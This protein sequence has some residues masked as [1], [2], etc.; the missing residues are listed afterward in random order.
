MAAPAVG[1]PGARG[2]LG[3]LWHGYMRRHWKLMVL[4]A[5]FM[6]IEG[7][8]LGVMAWMMGPM[9]DGI[10]VEH[11]TGA[12]WTVGLTVLG[13]FAIRAITSMAQQILMTRVSQSGAAHL[14]EDL[15]ARLMTLETGFHQRHPPGMLIER[16]QGDAGVIAGL[17]SALVTGFGRDL[18]GVV[19]LFS[20]ALVIDWRWTAVALVG[21]PLLVAPSLAAQSRVRRA[22][23]NARQVA[24]EMSTRL[25]EVFHGLTQI[26]LN[27]LETYQSDRFRRLTRARVR[28][29]TRSAAASAAIPALIDLMTG[30]GFLGVLWWGGS[31]IIAGDKTVGQFM[32]FFTA[33]AIAFEPLRRLGGLS[34]QWQQAA[35]SVERTRELMETG[36]ALRPPARPLPPPTGAPDIRF[37][38]VGL[39]YDGKIVLDGLSFTARAGETTAIVGPSGAGKSTVFNLLTRLV[40]PDRGRIT[41]GGVATGDMELADL[42][43]LFSV[44]TQDA[45]LFDETLAENILLGRDDVDPARLA[46]A[47]A[48]AQVAAFLPGLAQGIGTRVGPRGSALSGGQRQRVAIARALL[49]DAPVLLLDEATSAL[50]TKA[51]AAVQAALERMAAGRTT[52]VIAHRL[53]TV[54]GADRI[55]VMDGGRVV[56][57]GRHADLV[58]LGGVYAA[59]HALHLR[60]PV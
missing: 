44:V 8:T 23:T 29:E 56:E 31:E 59:L 45:A 13:L 51:E 54:L 53:G 48:D 16:V 3:W 14:R 47:L 41:L 20:V 26:K 38:D 7:G 2:H 34:G 25:D 55:I 5:L 15:L 21:V 37:H 50:D 30:L 36:P 58:A 10:F 22:A 27:R 32:S 52:L 33:I 57:E 4:A 28:A 18:V 1:V 19:S 9:F 24:A 49:R 35:A 42:R 46:A 17:W 60:E 43:G 11:R 12:I 40:D 6:A 39:S